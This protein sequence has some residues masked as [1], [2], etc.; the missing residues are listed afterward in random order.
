M[1][2]YIDELNLSLDEKLK[3]INNFEKYYIS[4]KG[5]VF[6]EINRDTDHKYRKNHWKELKQVLKTDKYGNQFY[7]IQLNSETIKKKCVR[8]S[9]LLKTYFPSDLPEIKID[10]NEIKKYHKLEDDEIVV[11]TKYDNLFISNYGK[12]FRYYNEHKLK[13][14]KLKV[15]TNQSGYYNISVKINGKNKPLR[16]HRLVA[17]NFIPNPDNLGS[18]DHIDSNKLNN[19]YKNLQWMTIGDNVSKYW[20]DPIHSQKGKKRKYNSRK[21]KV[22]DLNNNKSYYFNS[23]KECHRTLHIAERGITYYLDKKEDHIMKTR[24]LKF[25]NLQKN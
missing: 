6:K 9:T 20:K 13:W 12:V 15:T 5:R 7:E 22:I 23:I 3:K 2:D 24:N 21:L 17:E 11:K 4:N 19:Y 8:I 1:L 10:L 14:K 25:I 16:I 18:V